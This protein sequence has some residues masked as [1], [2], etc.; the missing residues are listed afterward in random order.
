MD[1]L[2]HLKYSMSVDSFE[3]LR[4]DVNEVG[5]SL[6]PSAKY[7]IIHELSFM[8][9]MQDYVDCPL[10]WAQV[11]YLTLPSVFPRSPSLS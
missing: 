11:S 7:G 5:Y 2:Y 8:S 10:P 3:I 1:L 4:H 6:E 9:N